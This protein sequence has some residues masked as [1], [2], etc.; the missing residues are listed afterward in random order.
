MSLGKLALA[1]AALAVGALFGKAGAIGAL[2]GLM[3]TAV[4]TVAGAFL[5]ARA[6]G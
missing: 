5:A 4:G 2:A 3:T 1:F 6:G